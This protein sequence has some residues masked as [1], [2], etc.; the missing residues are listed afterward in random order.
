MNEPSADRVPTLIAHKGDRQMPQ[1]KT[2]TVTIT[3]NPNP[4]P[5]GGAVVPVLISVSED[6][7]NLSNVDE[8]HGSTNPNAQIHWELAGN[9]PAGWEFTDD[10]IVVQNPRGKFNKKGFGKS[11]QT[12][13]REAKD[14]DPN[15]Q[16][17]KYTI[18]VTDGDATV[19]WDPWVINR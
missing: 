8:G 9:T 10:G 15:L 2:V 7:V 14:T 4:A 12:W 18:S 6:P 1:A 11:R 16:R 3:L 5:P 13:Q 17:Y 19:S